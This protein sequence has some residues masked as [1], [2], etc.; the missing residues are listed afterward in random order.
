MSLPLPHNVPRTVLEGICMFDFI[1]T[2]HVSSYTTL[3]W[4]QHVS[5]PS[6]DQANKTLIFLIFD[7]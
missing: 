5:C 7:V 6:Y 2:D 4:N 1:V 3:N